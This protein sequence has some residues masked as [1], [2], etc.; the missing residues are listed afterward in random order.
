M[1]RRRGTRQVEVSLTGLTQ[2]SPPLRVRAS[3]PSQVNKQLL[4]PLRRH[5]PRAPRPARTQ[6][7]EPP[8]RDSATDTGSTGHTGLE[9]APSPALPRARRRRQAST[10]GR[11][12]RAGRVASACVCALSGRRPRCSWVRGGG[13]A[14]WTARGGGVGWLGRGWG[15]LPEQRHCLAG[16]PLSCPRSTPPVAR[17]KTALGCAGRGLSFALNSR[18]APEWLWTGLPRGGAT[19]SLGPG[20]SSPPPPLPPPGWLLHR[21]APQ[22][23]H[24]HQQH[25]FPYRS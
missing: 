3:A 6:N 16:G 14:G 9:D 5:T 10:G 21:A 23:P 18:G 1:E 12:L 13:W 4:D 25:P 8:P 24:T 17:L 15:G 22:S 7:S 11:S 20:R 19:A 2:V